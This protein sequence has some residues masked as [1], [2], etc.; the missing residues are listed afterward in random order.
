M[1]RD[2]RVYLQQQSKHFDKSVALQN[3]QWKRSKNGIQDEEEG[4]V[5]RSKRICRKN[6]EDAGESPMS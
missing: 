3:K 1:V 6:E 4:E 2:G 5:G